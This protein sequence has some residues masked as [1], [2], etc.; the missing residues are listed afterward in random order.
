MIEFWHI[1]RAKVCRKVYDNNIL[2]PS[3]SL[4]HE[5]RDDYI[6]K[7]IELAFREYDLNC[8][9]LTHLLQF[10][11]YYHEITYT[12]WQKNKHD[13]KLIQMLPVL[14]KIS[15]RFLKEKR[16]KKGEIE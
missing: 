14:V 16:N 2:V 4:S 6:P 8:N 3:K 7:L 12:I 10:L 11:F 13:P 5:L 1:T 15:E 9:T